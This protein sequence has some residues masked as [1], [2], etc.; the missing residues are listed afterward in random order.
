M[1][2]SDRGKHVTHLVQVWIENDGACV[3]GAQAAA[4]ISTDSLR[5]YLTNV[6]KS[7]PRMSAARQMADELASNDYGRV[8]W[9]MVAE[10]LLDE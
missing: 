1:E 3:T 6:L 8:D 9:Q 7:A 4:R 2:H 10:D 5:V